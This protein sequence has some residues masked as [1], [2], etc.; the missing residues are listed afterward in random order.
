MSRNRTCSNKW[1]DNDL[2]ATALIPQVVAEGITQEL[3]VTLEGAA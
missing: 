1:S 3:L 2:D